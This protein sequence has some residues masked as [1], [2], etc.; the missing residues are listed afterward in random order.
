MIPEVKIIK[1]RGGYIDKSYQGE[2]TIEFEDVD[3]LRKFINDNHQIVKSNGITFKI[4]KRKK[5]K[6]MKIHCEV[7]AL[8]LRELNLEK[9]GI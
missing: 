3:R 5:S 1:K 6:A 8:T 7:K 4:T 2:A 9:L